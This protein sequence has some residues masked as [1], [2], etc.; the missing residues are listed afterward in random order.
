MHCDLDIAI[1]LAGR[2]YVMAGILLFTASVGSA[3]RDVALFDHRF[4]A[5]AGS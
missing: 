3:P 2:V 5:E 4:R 1:S